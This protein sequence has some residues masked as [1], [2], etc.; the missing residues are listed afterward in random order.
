MRRQSRCIAPFGTTA[1]LATPDV[2][3]VK[4]TA[5]GSETRPACGA[6][7]VGGEE[8]RE[9]DDPHAVERPRTSPT[10]TTVS[11]A[12]SLGRAA[13][14]ASSRSVS[15]TITRAPAVAARCSRNAPR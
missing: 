8:L 3:D 11:S 9:R 10:T 4:W 14:T 2:P 1:P 6:R 5:A 12:G 13:S 7:A 15:T